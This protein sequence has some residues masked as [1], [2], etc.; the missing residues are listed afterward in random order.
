MT[1]PQSHWA[2]CHSVCGKKTEPDYGRRVSYRPKMLHRFSA[3]Y[4]NNRKSRF[5]ADQRDQ[6]NIRVENDFSGFKEATHAISGLNERAVAADT[7]ARLVRAV[8]TVLKSAWHNSEPKLVSSRGFLE[9]L[10]ELRADRGSIA[11][12]L[13]GFG[14][15]ALLET[16]A[17]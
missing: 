9:Q 12:E 4:F 7:V 3:Q 11:E 10:S 13:G 16:V 17:L 2:L 6:K 5:S 1:L 15:G 8:S 14:G